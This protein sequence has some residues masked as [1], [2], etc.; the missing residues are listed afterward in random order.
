MLLLFDPVAFAIW[1]RPQWDKAGGF[2]QRLGRRLAYRLYPCEQGLSLRW[3]R[4]PESD[5]EIVRIRL[6]SSC[7]F[8]VERPSLDTPTA[9][10]TNP[11]SHGTEQKANGV[12]SSALLDIN[13]RSENGSDMD[14][15]QCET[16]PCTYPYKSTTL[17]AGADVSLSLLQLLDVM[18]CENGG[19][20]E[21]ANLARTSPHRHELQSLVRLWQSL[22]RPSSVFWRET[23]VFYNRIVD[24]YDV[25]VM[26]NDQAETPDK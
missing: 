22:G 12:V 23:R 20:A 3:R 13:R 16:S 11:E 1:P 21:V 26:S 8:N 10:K 4:D 24:S 5:Y 14:S 25:A 18:S 19:E 7:A 15:P 2:L 17:G 9:M 6:A